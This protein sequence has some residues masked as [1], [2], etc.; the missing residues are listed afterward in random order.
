[1]T[2]APR[3]VV[4]HRRTELDELVARH[5]TRQQAAFF[6]S[7]RDRTLEEV[8]ARHAA[9]Q[10][11]LA[12][13]TGAIP[14]DWRGGQIERED[15]HRFVF[16]PEDIVVAVGQDGLVANVAKYL[17]G[18]PVVGVNP[19]PGRNPGVLVPH[20]PHAVGDLL[21]AAAGPGRARADELRC[22][23]EA[24]TDDGQVLVALN[25]IYVGHASHQSAPYR[26]RTPDGATERHSSSGVLVGTGTGST[27]WCMSVWLERESTLRLPRPEEPALCG[28]VREACRP[29][30]PELRW[31]RGRS[32][33]A[34]S[35]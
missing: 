6:L 5:G 20:P 15:L 7:T 1:M 12:T 23:V 3:V 30:P 24:R 26:I 22:M 2:L 11:A 35:S 29:R 9:Q 4:I 28:F 31:P 27:G 18:Q 8:E 14:R 21:A 13:A 33:G 16:A 10:R 32:R 19:E 34:R 17:D 25:E